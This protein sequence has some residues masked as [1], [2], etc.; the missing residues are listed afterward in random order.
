VNAGTDDRYIIGDPSQMLTERLW[1]LPVVVTNSIAAGTFLLG[2]FD[3]GAQIWD[4]QDATIEVSREN[5]DNFV[6]N[7]VTILAEERIALTV[8]RTQAFITGSL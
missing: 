4:R 1:G 7:M 8:Y 3:M 5:S 6:K 2:S